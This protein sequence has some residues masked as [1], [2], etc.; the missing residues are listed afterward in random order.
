MTSR[1]ARSA[2]GASAPRQRAPST[3]S[4]ARSRM[5]PSWKNEVIGRIERAVGRG[6]R[7]RAR[8]RRGLWPRSRHRA[9][10][11]TGDPQPGGASGWPTGPCAARVSGTP[12]SR[13]M[14]SLTRHPLPVY[15]Q[16]AVTAPEPSFVKVDG[17]DLCRAARI[18]HWYHEDDICWVAECD[19]C[20]VPMV[21]WRFHGTEPPTEH[22]THMHERLRE[23]ATRQLGEIYVDDHMRNIPD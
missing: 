14:S 6:R 23:I 7:P 2:S 5:T 9:R 20:D 16:V 11:R 8:F 1:P 12:R 19:V 21:V 13:T 10:G 22:L 4:K 15:S 3:S 17:C 18:T